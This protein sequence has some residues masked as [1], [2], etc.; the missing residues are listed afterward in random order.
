MRE[1]LQVGQ[2]G[3]ERTPL[4]C[5]NM[6]VQIEHGGIRTKLQSAGILETDG[7]FDGV[8]VGRY[9]QR[10]TCTSITRPSWLKIECFW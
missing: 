8:S 7:I 10:Q 1:A 5:G 9:A 6:G 3:G 4:V 2:M